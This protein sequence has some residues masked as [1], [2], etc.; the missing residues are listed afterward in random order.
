MDV[1]NEKVLDLRHSEDF[2]IGQGIFGGFMASVS[3]LSFLSAFTRISAS[4]WPAPPLPVPALSSPLRPQ[5]EGL[6]KIQRRRG[7]L[8]RFWRRRL[9]F[10]DSIFSRIAVQK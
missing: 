9:H 5:P 1:G 4:S 3:S 10:V 7:S 2:R 8:L 6:A